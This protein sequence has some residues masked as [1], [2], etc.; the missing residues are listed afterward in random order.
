MSLEQKKAQDCLTTSTSV[1]T[2]LDAFADRIKRKLKERDERESECTK[3]TEIRHGQ[4]LQ[5]MTSIRK[6]LQEAS[7]INLGSRFQFE[8]D[9]NDW[10]GWPR[11]ELNLI[12]SIAPENITHGL[13]VTANDRSK[14]GTVQIQL[15]ATDEVLG[16]VHL[17]EPDQLTRLPFILK[18]SLRQF[19]DL[20]GAYILNP[21]RPEDMLA[22][23]TKA[24]ETDNLDPL[25]E[26]L[27][28]EDL[29]MH[30]NLEDDN[31]VEV[32]P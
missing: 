24:V 25:A 10:E 11:V 1:E 20:V 29:F 27:K 32:T 7:K 15:K 21:T 31:L 14:L 30:E 13:V 17:S 6:G 22:V 16:R 2:T 12:D 8:L 5:A 28:G 4:M 3:A 19:L 9:V 18:K 23:Q 26:S